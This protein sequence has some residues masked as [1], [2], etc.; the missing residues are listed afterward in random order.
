LPE[1]VRDLGDL[2]NPIDENSKLFLGGITRHF[3]LVADL[4]GDRRFAHEIPTHLHPY[5]TQFYASCTSV[6]EEI[7]GD[8]PCDR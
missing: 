6:T 8:A 4:L 1:R 5:L 7:I 3:Y 2:V